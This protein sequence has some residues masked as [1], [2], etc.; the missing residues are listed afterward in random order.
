MT[1][2]SAGPLNITPSAIEPG[3]AR[4][5]AETR[6]ARWISPPPC[7]LGAGGAGPADPQE[8]MLGAGWVQAE[9]RLARRRVGAELATRCVGSETSEMT[10]PLPSS[11]SISEPRACLGLGLGV[12]LG[13]GGCGCGWGWGW[14]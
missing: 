6:L 12:G 14:G 9:C 5:R 3:G 4:G 1:V 13:L 7:S 8:G 2:A 11:I 10:I